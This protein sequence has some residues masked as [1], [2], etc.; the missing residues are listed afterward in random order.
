MSAN[1]YT[2]AMLA[3]LVGVHVSRVRSWQR[4][5]WIVPAEQKHRLAYF[6][7]QEL[8]VARQLAE[9]S[10]LG[11]TPK[12][13]ERKLAE[14]QR[15]FP[16]VK[17]PLA[18]LTLV[19]DGRT[20]LVRRGSE[21]VEPGGQLRIDFGSIERDKLSHGEEED[22][23]AVIP[24]PAIFLSRPCRREHGQDARA[25]PE[26]GQDAR[27]TL[28][29]AA[30]QRLAAWAAELDEAGDLRAAAEMYRAALAAGGPQPELC[31]NLAEVLYRADEL[32]AAR[33]RYFMAIELDEDYVEARVNLGCVLLELGERELAVGAFT[34]ALRSHEAYADAH[35]HL[36]RALDDLER[37]GEALAHWRRFAEL[38]PESPWA[39]EARERLGGQGF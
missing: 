39:E 2:A 27:A 31:F 21:L 14:I 36:A 29:E 24:S 8:T 23:P 30:P 17:R 6:D 11:L 22:E 3:E 7:F 32:S 18:E 34:G 16:D 25:T 20:L 19:L 15:R 9:L 28:E 5:G 1:R 38:S 4:R 12:T 26:Y 33:E 37:G 13:I 35:Y 10:R